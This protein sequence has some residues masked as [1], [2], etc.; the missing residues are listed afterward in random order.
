MKWA[1]ILTNPARRALRDVPRPDI[2]QIDAA[3]EEMR[4]DPYS[5]DI[6]FLKGADRTL[7]RR[8]GSWR[9]LFEVHPDREIVLILAV[10]RRSSTTY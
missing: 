6:K 8:I 1:L 3:L 10:E 4:N 7:R 9:V 5:G 2:D